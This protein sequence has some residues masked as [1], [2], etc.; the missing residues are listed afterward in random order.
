M[1]KELSQLVLWETS[2]ENYAGVNELTEGINYYNN[3]LCF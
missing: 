1:L 2:S 3:N